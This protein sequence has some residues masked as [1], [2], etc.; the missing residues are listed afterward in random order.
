MAVM[1]FKQVQR[2]ILV[3]NVG[4]GGGWATLKELV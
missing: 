3:K 2:F 4:G 1:H